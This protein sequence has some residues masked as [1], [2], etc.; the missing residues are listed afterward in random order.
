M[1]N[2]IPH[3][4]RHLLLLL[5]SLFAFPAPASVHLPTGE[6]RAS[7]TDLRVKVR[8]GEVVIQRTW[9]ADDLNKGEYRWCPNPAWDDL[10]FELDH[11]EV[12]DGCT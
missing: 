4:H 1:P 2:M 6:Y 10:R 12:A 3:P 5:L 7:A 8:G 11:R 9:Q